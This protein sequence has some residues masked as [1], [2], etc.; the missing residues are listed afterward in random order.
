MVVKRVV[1]R[2][3]SDHAHAKRLA[4]AVSKIDA[5]TLISSQTNMVF[6]ELPDENIGVQ[7]GQFLAERGVNVLGGK[8]MRLVTHLGISAADTETVIAL[9]REYFAS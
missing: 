6:I 8:R 7:L 5:I 3:R 2:L 9:F 4:Q 1:D